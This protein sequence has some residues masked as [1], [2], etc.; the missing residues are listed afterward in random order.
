M[1][2]GARKLFGRR[3]SAAPLPN[4]TKTAAPPPAPRRETGAPAPAAEASELPALWR[5]IGHEAQD[6]VVNG[7]MNPG[8]MVGMRVGTDEDRLWAGL[9]EL[10]LVLRVPDREVAARMGVSELALTGIANYAARPG[11][12]EKIMD[13]MAGFPVEQ[14]S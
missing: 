12:A 8:L 10:G 14:G 4:P 6:R 11:V 13:A 7:A 9:V 2:G 5:A 3:T 1:F